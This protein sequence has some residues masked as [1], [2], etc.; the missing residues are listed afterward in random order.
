MLQVTSFSL[1]NICTVPCQI[2]Y[3][4]CHLMISL[5]ISQLGLVLSYHTRSSLKMLAPPPML[6]SAAGSSSMCN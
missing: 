2:N 1:R 5:M 3:K 6:S 4:Y